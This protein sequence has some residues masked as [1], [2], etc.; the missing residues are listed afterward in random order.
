M[1]RIPPKNRD[2]ACVLRHMKPAFG[3]AFMICLI[4][5][6]SVRYLS[7]S[8]LLRL[9]SLLVP[10]SARSFAVLAIINGA[11]RERSPPSARVR[12][13]TDIVL[14]F[15]YLHRAVT[16]D[17]SD[18]GQ[19][20]IYEVCREKKIL[21]PF[22]QPRELVG[23]YLD[24]VTRIDRLTVLSKHWKINLTS[25]MRA[26]RNNISNLIGDALKVNW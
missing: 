9:T 20:R 3:S 16:R 1:P 5:G 24:K 13:G 4:A 2:Q 21:A 17:L 8:R 6:P 7:R 22:G 18:S 25:R 23:R 14:C 11:I 15:I 26:D 19:T 12:D 10:F